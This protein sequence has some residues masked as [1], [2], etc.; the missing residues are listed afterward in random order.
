M[1]AP[2]RTDDSFMAIIRGLTWRST[3]RE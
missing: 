2:R 3:G 1:Q